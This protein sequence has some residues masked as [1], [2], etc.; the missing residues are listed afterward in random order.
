MD[1]ER[2]IPLH[3]IVR[4]ERPIS[5]FLTLHSIILD[6]AEA[7]TH[8]DTE[9]SQGKTPFDAAVTGKCLTLLIISL[10]FLSPRL[11]K[12]CN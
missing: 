8:M 3:I 5:D 10:F 9:N 1:N 12:R 4:Y 11:N 2:N 6:L 7:G